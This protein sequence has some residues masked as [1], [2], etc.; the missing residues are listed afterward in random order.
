MIWPFV[1]R[2]TYR[3]QVTRAEVLA[4]ELSPNVK[5]ASDLFCTKACLEIANR[6]IARQ[7][8]REANLKA[9]LSQAERKLAKFERRRGVGGKFETAGK[10]GE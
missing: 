10:A 3:A 8:A 2:S 5:M 4:R 7:E 1:L 6:Q 9:L